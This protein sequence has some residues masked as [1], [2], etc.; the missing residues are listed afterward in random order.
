MKNHITIFG[1]GNLTRSILNG[2]YLS[3]ASHNIDVID[4]D[5]KKRIGL[6]KFGV[7]F[8]TACTDSISKSD[9][10]LLLV[11]PKDSIELIKSIDRFLNKK[12]IIISFM[13]GIS[14]KQIQDNLS[15]NFNIIRAMTNLTI[16]NGEAIIFYYNKT[17]FKKNTMKAE[18][19]FKK[20][21]KIKKCKS[22]DQLDKLTAL[23]GSGPAYYVYFNDI[24]TKSFMKLGFNRRDSMIYA[25][26]LISETSNLLKD[27]P[28]ARNLIKAIASKGGTTEAALLKLKNDKVQEKVLLAIKSAYDK[29]K[30]IL[31]K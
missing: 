7:S 10:I 21:S 5:K 9:F 6:K 14:I 2:I 13:A 11:K 25:D 23:Y 18:V 22:E 24:I 3:D 30:N 29:S 8:R 4:V 20:F 15:A 31:K 16:S 12:T 26:N 19:F 28:N 1:A 17:P 27:S